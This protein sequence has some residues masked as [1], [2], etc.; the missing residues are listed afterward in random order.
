M[1]TAHRQDIVSLSPPPS[2]HQTCAR[3]EKGLSRVGAGAGPVVPARAY[4]NLRACRLVK[5]RCPSRHHVVWNPGDTAQHG[6][7]SACHTLCLCL[8][9]AKSLAHP[10]VL[11]PPPRY[12][13]QAAYNAALAGGHVAPMI[14]T[15]NILST[16]SGPEYQFL[17]GEGGLFPGPF[18]RTSALLINRLTNGV[19]GIRSLRPQGRSSSCNTPAASFRSPDNEPEPAFDSTSARNC[20]H[21]GVSPES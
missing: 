9:G 3:S 20:R 1:I 17:V 7:P 13:T 21:Q 19:P 2:Y 6:S 14:E 16:P 12:P 18:G 10:S 8:D 4:V 11:P 15:N 5:S